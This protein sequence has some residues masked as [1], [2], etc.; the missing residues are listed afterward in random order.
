MR[1]NLPKEAAI[2]AQIAGLV[3]Q[4]LDVEVNSLNQLFLLLNI[5]SQNEHIAV[6]STAGIIL[7]H[8][9]STAT[10]IADAANLIIG[11]KVFEAIDMPLDI[12]SRDVAGVLEKHIERYITCRD[13]V[14]MVDMGSLE[15][16]HREMKIWPM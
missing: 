7:S 1:Q 10:S 15:Q 16:I 4:N 9:Y 12:H 14:L 2:A 5:K 8:G 11:K 3:K 6:A 13:I